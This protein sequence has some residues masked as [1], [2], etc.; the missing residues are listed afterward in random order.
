MNT[1]KLFR[2][3]LKTFL[4]K[5]PR[6]AQSTLADDLGMDRRHL[7]SFLKGRRPFS[8]S[9]REAIAEHL[10]YSYLDFLNMGRE[11]LETGAEIDVETDENPGIDLEALAEIGEAASESAAKLQ[12][13][14]ALIETFIKDYTAP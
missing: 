8:E 7:S 1:E 6:G 14:A 5:Q 12:D 9:R 4:A 3:T 2:I 10:G 11:Q 13:L